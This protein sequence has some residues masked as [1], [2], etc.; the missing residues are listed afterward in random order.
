MVGG[1]LTDPETKAVRLPAS[2][3]LSPERTDAIY[4]DVL[5]LLTQIGYDGLTVD[6]IAARTR[7][8]KATLYRQ[9][10]GK[11]DLVV[12]ALQQKNPAPARID[13]GSLRGD[14]L[15]IANR[16]GTVAPSDSALLAGLA[17]AG[18]VHPEL[19][20]AL[21]SR[22]FEPY[23][24]AIREVLACAIERGDIVASAAA[25]EFCPLAFMSLMPGRA[26]IEGLQVTPEFLAG[27][28]DEVLLPALA[29]GRPAG[30]SGDGTTS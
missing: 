13:T 7:I 18:S 20:S 14:L 5:D 17:H 16:L 2:R 23:A 15:A 6:A 11:A 24:D 10:Q 21:R 25:S 19:G 22:L 1:Q 30:A 26:L 4:D 8:S 12:A 9:W 27:F 3:R 28:V 29:A